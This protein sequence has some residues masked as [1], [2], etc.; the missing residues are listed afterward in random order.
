MNK[1]VSIVVP[2]YNVRKYLCECLDSLLAQTYKE[3][4]IVLVDDGSTDESN[5][6][7]RQY[8]NKDKR[9]KLIVQKNQGAAMAKNT[10]LD[11]TTGDYITFLDSDD[12]VEPQ[13]IETMVET[14]ERLDA[15]VVECEFAKKYISSIE[16]EK[17]V[18]RSGV[19]TCEQYLEQ[20][21]DHWTCSLFWNKLFKAEL[22][23]NIRF[24]KERRCI[25]DEFFTYKVLSNAKIIVHIE[26]MLYYYRQRLSSA[27]SNEKNRE[28]KTE[29]ALEIMIERY[30]WIKE[31]FPKLIKKYLNH[32]LEML[33]YFSRTGYF[34]ESTIKKFESMKKYY[35]TECIKHYP[36]KIGLI[37]VIKLQMIT[38]ARLLENLYSQDE[39]D[40]REF[41]K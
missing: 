1:K 35:L 17:D 8:A 18:P 15:D 31:R 20:Y 3:I 34:N 38:K 25:D 30:E 2:V 23:E 27:V 24:R 22:M 11:N 37:N 26:N 21:L 40:F 39:Q 10:G 36:G 6:I 13:W 14:L 16:A 28:Q 12:L 19:Y 4:E 5:S 9:I 29:D 33:H 7:C 32:D 41:F